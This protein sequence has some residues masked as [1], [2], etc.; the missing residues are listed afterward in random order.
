[1][2]LV[3]S[4]VCPTCGQVHSPIASGFVYSLEDRVEECKEC[5]IR[6]RDMDIEDA[7]A[8]AHYA[9]FQKSGGLRP[10]SS[11]LVDRVEMDLI[12]QELFGKTGLAAHWR[13][14]AA[15]IKK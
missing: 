12:R 5:R 6:K 4:A 7:K 9:A 13:R 10:V 1:M 11:D 3:R 8:E 14:V 15:R 2:A